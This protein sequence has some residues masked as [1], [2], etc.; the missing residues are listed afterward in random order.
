MPPQGWPIVL[1][2][3]EQNYTS[4][5]Q[6]PPPPPKPNTHSQSIAPP[7]PP[8]PLPPTLPP[9]APPIPSFTSGPPNP[10]PVPPPINITTT[11]PSAPLAASGNV[12]LLDSIRQFNSGALKKTNDKTDKSPENTKRS[13]P[14][15]AEDSSMLGQL[16]KA[17]GE[18]QM[19]LRKFSIRR[20]V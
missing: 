17:L 15:V 7:P 11:K 10:P 9:P 1:V 19:F 13:L 3:N 5:H 8:P 12:A 18:R 16:K 2:N 4:H 20:I 6:A 14:A